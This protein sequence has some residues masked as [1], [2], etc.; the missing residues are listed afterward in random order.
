MFLPRWVCL[1]VLPA[2]AR[3]EPVSFSRDIK[4]V[5]ARQCA[6]CHQE[7]SKQSDLLVTSYQGLQKGG[8][9]GAAWVAGKPDDSVLIRYLTGRTEPRMPLGGKPL[10][11]EQIALFRRWVEEGARDDSA[12]APP[13]SQPR[14]PAAYRSAPLVTAFAISPDGGTIATS[15]YHEILL[16]D[17]AG[18]LKG[19]LP[20]ASMRI[21]SLSFTPGGRKLV[22]VGGDPAQMGEVQ[23][24]DTAAGKLLHSIRASTD[25]LF[26][27]SLSPDG[28]LLACGAADKAIRLFDIEAGK[29][30]RKMEHHEDWVFQTTFGVDGK[31]L[32]TVGRDRAAKLIEAET[33]R[34]I[35]NVNLLRD[36][37]TAVVRHPKKDWV[38][39]GG[40]ERIPY[41]YRM[42]RPRAMRIADDST[43]IRKFDRQDGPILALAISPDGSRLAVGSETGD[44]RVYDTESGAETAKCSGHSGGI[45]ALQFTPDGSQLITGGFDGKLRVYDMKGALVRAFVAAPL[46][47]AAKEVAVR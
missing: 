10:S 24:W 28:K 40:A 36:A 16:T 23:V 38:A 6:A 47:P 15:G 33:G 34:F 29:E 42:D 18:K 39:I 46:D 30:V 5:L 21:H 27:G 9:K 2:L 35:E 4:P 25:T 1:L 45:Y 44:V 8:R 41:L 13:V 32:V 20:G 43:L 31:R 12:A 7:Q 3:T 11:D 17:T 37:L 22:A 14:A 19:R 26:G